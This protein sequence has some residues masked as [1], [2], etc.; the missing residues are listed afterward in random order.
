[1]APPPAARPAARAVDVASVD[2]IVKA[3]YDVVSGPAGGRDWDRLRSL[4]AADGR[5]GAIGA[6]A[7][8]GFGLRAMTVED[9]I[10]MAGKNFSQ[11]GFFESE[12]ARSTDTFGQLV[13]VFSTYEARRSPADATPFMRGINSIQLYHDGQR[14]YVVS[15]LWRAEDDKLS[16]PERY[17]KNR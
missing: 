7:A 12:V 1:M 10:V 17:R 15:L 2:A 3:L 13:H 9:Y 5:M 11:S 8:G 4:F 16:L 14:W 6:R